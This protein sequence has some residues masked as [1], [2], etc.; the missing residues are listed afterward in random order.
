MSSFI[1]PD[2]FQDKEEAQIFLEVIS[3]FKVMIKA[4]SKQKKLADEVIL[5]GIKAVSD[6][7]AQ[8]KALKSPNLSMFFERVEQEDPMAFIDPDKTLRHKQN[9]YFD[10]LDKGL[11]EDFYSDHLNAIL[12][13]NFESGFHYT[14]LN[15]IISKLFPERPYTCQ[16]IKSHRE[17]SLINFGY[18]EAPNMRMDLFLVMDNQRFVIIENKTKTSEHSEQT[19]HYYN[20]CL[21]RHSETELYPI[22]LSPNS[23]VASCSA[24]KSLNYCDLFYLMTLAIDEAKVTEDEFLLFA[25]FYLELKKQFYDPYHNAMKRAQKYRSKCG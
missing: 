2:I 15:L 21:L 6:Q 4:S 20:A 16:T 9:G 13:H 22:M 24:Y 10:F 23:Q 18:E 5:S 14:L 8:G 1:Y 12:N 7:F 11:D 19:Q 25:D 3:G 17:I